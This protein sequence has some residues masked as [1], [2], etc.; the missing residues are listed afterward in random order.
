MKGAKKMNVIELYDVLDKKIK[1]FKKKG[2]SKKQAIKRAWDE[3]H[4]EIFM[5][6]QT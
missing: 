3:Y 2:L 4:K 6:Q 5:K 1:K